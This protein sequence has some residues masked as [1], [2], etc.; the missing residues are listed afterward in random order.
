MRIVIIGGTG[1][2]GSY[3]TPRLVEVGHTA[4]CVSRGQK[5]PYQKHAAWQVVEYVEMD[6][7]IEEASEN[8]GERIAALDAHV[9]IDLTCYKPES[10]HQLV[11]A[12]RGRIEHL[13]HC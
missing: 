10:A 6:R 7:E 2:I 11:D 5:T 3:L 8:F 9:V 4:L 12:L 1:H 13:L